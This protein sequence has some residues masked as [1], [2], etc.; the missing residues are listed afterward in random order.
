V[1]SSTTFAVGDADVLDLGKLTPSKN[2]E[3]R[4][5][6]SCVFYSLSYKR[7]QE[8]RKQCK[9][10]EPFDVPVNALQQFFAVDNRARLRRLGGFVFRANFLESSDVSTRTALMPK[11]NDY[12][13]FE[14]NGFG[15]RRK[16]RSGENGAVQGV[17]SDCFSSSQAVEK[18]KALM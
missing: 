5:K 3:K 11:R 17:R 13:L 7:Q 14:E 16:Y 18:K 1:R 4:S 10:N 6:C 9:I 12:G 8:C 2:V 15:G